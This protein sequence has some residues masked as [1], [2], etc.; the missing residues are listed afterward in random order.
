MKHKDGDGFATDNFSSKCIICC[1]IRSRGCLRG[2]AWIP[3]VVAYV[4]LCVSGLRSWFYG[5]ES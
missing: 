1:G 3:V 5:L 2:H 4:V